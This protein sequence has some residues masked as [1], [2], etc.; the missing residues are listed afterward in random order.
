M[1][2]S[3]Q[4]VHCYY[5]YCMGNSKPASQAHIVLV[6]DAI[7][8]TEITRVLSLTS[9]GDARKKQ[10]GRHPRPVPTALLPP[11]KANAAATRYR[12]FTHNV[13][14]LVIT[15]QDGATSHGVGYL[16]DSNIV[17]T[18]AHTLGVHDQM[19]TRVRFVWIYKHNEGFWFEAS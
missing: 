18:C 17:L 5:L 11:S 3:L 1:S 10:S 4:G 13:G 15:N 2:L 12:S 19:P 14:L 7:V 16:V 9:M 8:L 6:T